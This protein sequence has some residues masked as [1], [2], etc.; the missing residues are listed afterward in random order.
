MFTGEPTCVPPLEQFGGEPPGPQRKNVAVPAAGDAP[1]KVAVSVTDSPTLIV[2]WLT[3]VA[4]C[5][6]WQV[7]NVPSATS[8]GV[9]SFDWE[10]RVSARTR[11]TPGHD[12]PGGWVTG[13]RAWE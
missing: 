2:D 8:L 5:G 6:G 9:A 12:A 7:V 13:M 3:W 4:I 10:A 1:L 11:V